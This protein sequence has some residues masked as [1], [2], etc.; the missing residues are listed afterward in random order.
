MGYVQLEQKALFAREVEHGG[1]VRRGRRKLDRPVSTRRPMH[2]VLTSQRACGPWSLRRHERAVRDALREM[3]GRFGI[4][5]YDFAN[6]LTSGG[7]APVELSTRDWF[8][9]L[10]VHA[11]DQQTFR[12]ALVIHAE[13]RVR[14]TSNRLSRCQ[15]MLGTI[16]RLVS[17]A[18]HDFQDAD[19]EPL[20]GAG[21]ALCQVFDGTFEV[22][23]GLRRPN[24]D[25]G[26]TWRSTR[27]RTSS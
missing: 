2:V 4:V 21:V 6:R 7:R 16:D 13:R 9:L 24:D 8:T 12:S 1:T 11:N 20:G 26:R 22:F 27:A 18:L 14:P 25:Q 10:V 23:G 3:A 15:K 19:G 5:V 17:K